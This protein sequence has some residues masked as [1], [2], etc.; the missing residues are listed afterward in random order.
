MKQVNVNMYTYE[1]NWLHSRDR[2]NQQK[3]KKKL[4]K[5]QEKRI[6]FVWVERGSVFNLYFQ[7]TKHDHRVSQDQKI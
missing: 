4:D 5:T 3:L 7:I 1:G 2:I 6:C